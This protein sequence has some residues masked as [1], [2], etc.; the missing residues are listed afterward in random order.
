MSTTVRRILIGAGA[1]AIGAGS[2]AAP[3]SAS[4]AGAAPTGTVT[5]NDLNVRTAPTPHSRAVVQVDRGFRF[6]I[7]CVAQ[8]PSVGG[9]TSWYAVGP[10]VG[11]WVSANYVKARGDVRSCGDDA[12]VVGRTTGNPVLNTFD[13]PSIKDSSVTEHQPGSKIRVHCYVQNTR[14]SGSTR[15]Y[16]TGDWDAAGDWVPGDYLTLPKNDLPIC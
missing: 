12:G 16:W 11:K 15:W 14:A 5:V 13:G 3:L 4:A 7:R 8:G 1:L 2:L 9:N 6:G 10:D